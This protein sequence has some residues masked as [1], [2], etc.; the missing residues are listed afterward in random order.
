MS[1]KIAI[2]GLLQ[3]EEGAPPSAILVDITKN[4]LTV[5]LVRA[6]KVIETKMLEIHQAAAFTGDKILKHFE[7]V[8]L[9]PS[10]IILLSE[11]EE[12][13][14]EFVSHPWSKSL[15]FFHLPQITNL[16]LGFIVKAFLLGM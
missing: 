8:E 16:Q 1:T 14:Q 2:V 3:K 10:R 13:V 15:P 12:L 6:G 11:D 4:N 5:S 9:L 7:N